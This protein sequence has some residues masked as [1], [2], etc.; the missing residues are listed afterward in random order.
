MPYFSERDIEIPKLFEFLDRHSN[1]IKTILDVGCYGSQYLEELK[2]RGKVV[3]GVDFTY[4]EKEKKFLWQ[5]LTGDFLEIDFADYNLV[6]A[7]STIEHYGIKQKPDPDYTV[8]QL[9]FFEKLLLTANH[10][11]FVTFPYGEPA[12]HEKEFSVISPL[13]LDRFLGALNNYSYEIEFYYNEEPQ[14]G[15]GW[16]EIER[17]EAGR[18]KYNPTIGVQCVCIL[19]V[20]KF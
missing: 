2:K 13:L 8:L 3:D 11:L 19:K 18:V 17:E 16:R 6:I 12:I 15:E 20:K 5:Y 4:G 10:Y 14:K 7:L 9:F 1:E